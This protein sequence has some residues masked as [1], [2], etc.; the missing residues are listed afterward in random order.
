MADRAS[1]NAEVSKSNRQNVLFIGALSFNFNWF[2]RYRQDAVIIETKIKIDGSKYC[3]NEFNVKL[4]S[5][6]EAGKLLQRRHKAARLAARECGR[7]DQCHA[8][9]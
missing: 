4:F 3:C 9:L 8:P 7:S 2:A 1:A 6:Q 5:F